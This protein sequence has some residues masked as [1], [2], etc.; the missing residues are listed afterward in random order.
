[1]YNET[2][3][4]RIREALINEKDVV[5]KKMFQ[6]LSFMVDD[7]L[8]IGVRNDEI[9]CRIDHEQAELELEKEYCRP[10]IHG[11]RIAKG[12]IFVSEDGYH[13]NKD[14]QY[15]ID[16]CLDYNKIVQKAKKK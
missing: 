10:M 2:L 13:R 6:G 11:Q 9:L 7:K 15:Y 14:F 4:N 16:L 8:C 1:M 3:V 5:E 12:Y